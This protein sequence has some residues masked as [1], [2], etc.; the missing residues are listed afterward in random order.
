[1]SVFP[2]LS[3]LSLSRLHCVVSHVS[4]LHNTV[5]FLFFLVPVSMLLK[6]VSHT[7]NIYIYIL[8]HKCKNIKSDFCSILFLLQEKKSIK[9]KPWS[10]LL[11]FFFSFFTMCKRHAWLGLHSP[12]LLLDFWFFLHTFASG[13]E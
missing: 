1:M 5:Y 3:L 8:S 4:A 12:S 10:K 6:G 11:L 9:S 7:F 13:H 2:P